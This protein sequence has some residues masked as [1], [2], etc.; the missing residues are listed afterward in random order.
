M[1]APEPDS[2]QPNSPHPNEVSKSLYHL[3]IF[4]DHL[5]SVPLVSGTL[6]VGRS[7]TNHLQLN[8][9]LLSRKHCSLTLNGERLTL[10][11]LN[12]SNGTYVNGSRIGTQDLSIDDIVELGQS[13]LVIFDGRSW[14]RGEGL[15]NLRN[16]VK[17]QELVQILSNGGVALKR[18][19]PI[20]PGPAEDGVRLQKGLTEKERAFLRWLER[21]E[22]QLLPELV[23]D[24]LSHKL[25]SLLVRNSKPVRAAFTTVL[26]EMLKPEFVARFQDIHE[27]RSAVRSQ[28]A[29]ELSELS[30]NPEVPAERDLLEPAASSADAETEPGEETP[31]RDVSS[32]APSSEAPSS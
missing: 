23:T 3:A 30:G 7:K 1:P 9:D 20:Y 12:S 10:V 25:V 6:L 22:N 29:K 24:Y 5:R 18:C 28:V 26:E 14:G 32:E 31:P 13:V 27:L 11:D 8:D 21:A 4:D 16:P 2:P 15:M 19:R 17:A